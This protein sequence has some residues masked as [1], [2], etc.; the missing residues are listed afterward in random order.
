ML[1]AVLAGTDRGRAGRH[2]NTLGRVGVSLAK[3]MSYDVAGSALDESTDLTSGLE[4]EKKEN[5]PTA[6]INELSLKG[7][8]PATGMKLINKAVYTSSAVREFIN[9]SE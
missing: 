7:Y 8:R 3:E 2:R 5:F 9:Q 4:W 1:L 6:S